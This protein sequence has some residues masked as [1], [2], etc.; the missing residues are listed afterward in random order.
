MKEFS[1]NTLLGES[2]Y[3]VHL[4]EIRKSTLGGVNRRIW[5]HPPVVY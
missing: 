1:L 4:L 2:N 5:N 3:L